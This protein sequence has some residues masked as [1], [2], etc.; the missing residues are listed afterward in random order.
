MTLGAVGR[1]TVVLAPIT[2]TRP[3]GHTRARRRGKSDVVS[4]GANDSSA[5]RNVRLDQ[6]ER[7]SRG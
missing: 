2:M 4:N 6:A 1:L 7:A 5:G 3:D